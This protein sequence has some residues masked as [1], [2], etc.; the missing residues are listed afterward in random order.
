MSDPVFG[1]IMRRRVRYSSEYGIF[2]MAQE[3]NAAGIK[4]VFESRKAS[5]NDVESDSGSTALIVRNFLLHITTM[6]YDATDIGPS[7]PLAD[8]SLNPSRF[9]LRPEQIWI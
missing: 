7:T 9:S 8:S 6:N 4:S 2:L 3:G 1:L 5:P